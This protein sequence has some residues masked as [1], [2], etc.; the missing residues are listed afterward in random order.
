[1]QKT[2]H[3]F[4]NGKRKH[5]ISEH[6]MPLISSYMTFQNCWSLMK[7]AIQQQAHRKS[8]P[9]RLSDDEFASWS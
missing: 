3:D 7:E 6:G 2:L 4:I 8:M 5:V 1:M 9:E